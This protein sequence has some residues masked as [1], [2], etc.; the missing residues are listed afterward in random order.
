MLIYTMAIIT[1]AKSI[2]HGIAYREYEMIP[3][4]V[5][6][7]ALVGAGFGVAFCLFLSAF[8]LVGINFWTAPEEQLKRW[9]WWFVG[10]V[11]TFLLIYNLIAVPWS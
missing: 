3:V 8:R 1:A 6:L 5:V 10:I 4:Y 11:G 2:G 7:G 9:W